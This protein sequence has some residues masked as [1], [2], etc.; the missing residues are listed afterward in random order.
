MSQ[1]AAAR[2]GYGIALLPRYLAARDPRLVQVSLG[3]SLPTRDL[4]L[5]MRRD[6]KD[7]PRVRAVAEYF[8]DLPSRTATSGRLKDGLHA[9]H[10]AVVASGLQ[11]HRD[12][13]LAAIAPEPAMMSIE[14][15]LDHA[16]SFGRATAF[17]VAELASAAVAVHVEVHDAAGDGPE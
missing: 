9:L 1:A 6:L 14:C 8:A 5:L 3:K 12:A 7:V 13:V 17:L 4:W 10:G 2:A 16:L 15:G 11:L